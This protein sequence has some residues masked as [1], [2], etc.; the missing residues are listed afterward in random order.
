MS[1]M[2]LDRRKENI[3]GEDA[4]SGGLRGVVIVGRSRNSKEIRGLRGVFFTDSKGFAN[5]NKLFAALYASECRIFCRGIPQGMVIRAG[6]SQHSCSRVY[7]QYEEN[8]MD[9]A[10]SGVS[11]S[12]PC[13]FMSNP[14][15]LLCILVCACLDT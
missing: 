7:V 13:A 6:Q 15:T 1:T 9:I 3:K 14:D 11:I 5:F 12:C 2:N 8:T 4:S 10:C